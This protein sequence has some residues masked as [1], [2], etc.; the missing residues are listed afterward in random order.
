MF[1]RR[2]LPLPL[3]QPSLLVLPSLQ[4]QETPGQQHLLRLWQS[5]AH[6]WQALITQTVSSAWVA[7][8]DHLG[9]WWDDIATGHFWCNLSFFTFQPVFQ[10]FLSFVLPAAVLPGLSLYYQAH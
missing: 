4:D 8:L 9:L 2:G 1:V 3:L 5:C 6:C 10:T 7:L